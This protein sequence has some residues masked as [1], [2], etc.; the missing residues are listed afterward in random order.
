MTIDSI[1]VSETNSQRIVILKE[2]SCERYLPM[3]I[4]TAEADAIAI[5]LQGVLVPR[6]LTHDLLRSVIDALG[7]AV[8]HIIIDNMKEDTF[9]AR[10]FLRVND[11][12]LEVDSRPSDALALAVRISAPIYVGESIIE[13][14]GILLDRETGNVIPQAL[15]AME[16]NP[17]PVDEA[18]LKK[19]SAFKDFVQ[20]LNLKD[21]E[22]DE[23]KEDP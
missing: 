16:D 1:R 2:K 19:L 5:K 8:D 20:N 23:K 18:E 7:A 6:P 22:K 17:K 13:K 14:A 4:G 15:K 9:Y 3:W 11:K 12:M 21:L 10:I